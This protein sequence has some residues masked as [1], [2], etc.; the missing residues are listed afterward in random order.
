LVISEP[1]L[2]ETLDGGQTFRWQRIPGGDWVGVWGHHVANVKLNSKSQLCYRV[3]TTLPDC[4]PALRR[5]LCLDADFPA[6][7]D[8]LPWRSDPHI[9]KC[10]AAFP[11]LRIP[12]QPFGETLL[13]FLCSATKQIVQIK[14][15][16]AL[17]AKNHGQG[18]LVGRVD[19]NALNERVEVNTF[20]P[21]HA[22]PTWSQLAA[23]PEADLRQCLLGFR[24]RYISAIAQFLAARPGWLEATEQ[25]PYA[26]AKFRLME[27]PGVGEKVADCVLLFGAGKLEAFPVDTWILKAM[28]KRYTLTDWK[29]AQI[30]H[31]GRQHFG[32]LAGLAQQYLFSY[33]RQQSRPSVA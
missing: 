16:V 28:A 31:F 32:P 21:V 10:I 17:L 30:A 14:E 11:G 24:A 13:C 33:E 4:D 6:L 7:T 23:I 1:V 8:S 25:L 22:L 27:L 5:Y 18:I 15:M 2:A 19:P 3:P 26:E 29:P 9:A 20:H 12:R